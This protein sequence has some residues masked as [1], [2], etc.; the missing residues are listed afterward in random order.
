MQA[1]VPVILTF[2]TALSMLY[3]AATT[4]AAPINFRQRAVPMYE[5]TLTTI[6]DAFD[7]WQ[8]LRVILQ[9]LTFAA[10]LW[11]VFVLG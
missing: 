9:T 7:R 3:T 5:A 10:M 8:T 6:F 11:A 4:R 1:T 2:A